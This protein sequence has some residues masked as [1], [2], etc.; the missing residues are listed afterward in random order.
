MCSEMYSKMKHIFTF[1]G[2]PPSLI[3]SSENNQDNESFE[4]CAFLLEFD[5]K[6]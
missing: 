5:L 1:M 2:K 4:K 6:F 3:L